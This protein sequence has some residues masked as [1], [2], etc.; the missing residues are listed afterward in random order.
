[1]QI[2]AGLIFIINLIAWIT[3]DVFCWMHTGATFGWVGLIGI[4]TFL[5]SWG[6]SGEAVVSPLDYFLQPEWDI[7]VIK[8]KWANSTSLI[9]MALFVMLSVLFNWLDL[10]EFLN[11]NI[12]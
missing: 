3:F 1:M 6:L 7:F 11:I 9:V 12:Q 10:R 8:L 2:I 5:I 4:V